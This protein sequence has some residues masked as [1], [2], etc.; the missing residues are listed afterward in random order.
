MVDTLFNYPLETKLFKKWHPIATF[1]QQRRAIDAMTNQQIAGS[2]KYNEFTSLTWMSSFVE[3]VY[4]SSM[5]DYTYQR[6]N[7]DDWKTPF[8]FIDDRGGDCEDFCIYWLDRLSQL[9]LGL[10]YFEMVVGQIPARQLHAALYVYADM[11]ADYALVMDILQEKVMEAK[12]H[13]KTFSPII[14]YNVYGVRVMV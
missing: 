11:K 7:G 1:F 13:Q 4:K 6:D 10:P 2:A 12:L 5:L 3:R 8:R 14:A 9:G